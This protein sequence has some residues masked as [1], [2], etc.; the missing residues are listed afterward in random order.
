MASSCKFTLS[1]ITGIAQ[2]ES[3]EYNPNRPFSFDHNGQLIMTRRPPIAVIL[4]VIVICFALGLLNVL[5]REPEVPSS[6]PTSLPPS[7]SE[8]AP[9]SI[10]SILIIGVDDLTRNAPL[11]RAIW[12]ASNRPTENIIYL[13]GIP[14]NTV[15]PGEQD[16]TLSDVFEWTYQ[17]G[18]SEEF[19]DHLYEII[20]LHP[21]LTILLD[22]IAFAKTIDYLGGAE[23]RGRTLDGESVLTFLSLSWDQPE[24]LIQNQADIIR[25]II[26][27]ALGLPETPELTELFALIPDHASLSMEISQAVGLI[28]PLRETPSESIFIILL[29][30]NNQNR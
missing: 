15:I 22:D 8:T 19:I 28:L 9:S 23:I 11:L 7:P 30:E 16:A 12:I 2:L 21:T 24:I 5:L 4:L 18:I 3:S 6:F 14:M 20:P 17:T 26:P 10:N 29:D 25:S 1:S 13:H 27:K